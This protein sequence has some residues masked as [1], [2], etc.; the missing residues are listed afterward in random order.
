MCRILTIFVTASIVVSSGLSIEAVDRWVE[1][2]AASS[3]QRAQSDCGRFQSPGR[4]AAGTPF[5]S[6][7]L[8]GLEFR[9]SA[10]WDISVGPA[11]EPTMDYLWLVSPPLQ[12]APHLMIGPG[13]GMTARESAR[14]ERPL[15][16]VMTRA[17]YDAARAAID[18]RRAEETLKQLD[19]LGRGHLSF[20][21]TDYRIRDVTLPDG[22]Q[23]DAFEWVAFK[24]EACVPRQGPG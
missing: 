18:H 23:G 12:T 20:T 21:I 4:L 22:R 11:A 3:V 16:F 8:R 2:G 15:R 9:L 17:D 1:G 14:I 10:G 5:R 6:P 7:L 24:G 19:Q 13:Y